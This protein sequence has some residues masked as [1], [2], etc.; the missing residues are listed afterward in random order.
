MNDGVLKSDSPVSI[1]ENRLRV[2]KFKASSL[3][4]AGVY[5]VL[6]L[7]VKREEIMMAS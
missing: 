3:S 5:S 1:T 4:S 7:L 6:S 2:Q